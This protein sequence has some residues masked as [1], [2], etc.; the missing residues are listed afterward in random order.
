MPS[1]QPV[2]YQ[3]LVRVFEEDRFRLA[4]QRGDHLIY[5]NRELSVPWLSRHIIPSQYS[6]SATCCEQL[7]C[8]GSTI[9]SCSVSGKYECRHILGPVTPRLEPQETIWTSVSN[10]R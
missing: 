1:I 8:R 7:E 5:T 9:F 6:S 2:P 3:I 10:L 4:R